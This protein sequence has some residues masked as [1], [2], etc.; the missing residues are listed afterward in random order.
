MIVIDSSA[1]V[2]IVTGEPERERFVDAILAS[3]D[4]VMSVVSHFETRTVL[5]R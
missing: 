2:A 3:P 4:P 5:L 1:L